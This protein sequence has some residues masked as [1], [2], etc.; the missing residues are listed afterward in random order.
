MRI[1]GRRILAL[2]PAACSVLYIAA[3]AQFALE[4]RLGI[5]GGPAVTE[6]ERAKYADTER[7]SQAQWANAAIGVL[8]LAVDLLPL[9]PETRS[10][11]PL[12]FVIPPALLGALLTAFGIFILVGSRHS[13]R[14]GHRFGIFCVIWGASTVLPAVTIRPSQLLRRQLMRRGRNGERTSA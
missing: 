4:G 8:I 12:A 1:I 10:R 11:R 3:K 9:V 14:G 7:I 13:E 2:L 6:A 5:H